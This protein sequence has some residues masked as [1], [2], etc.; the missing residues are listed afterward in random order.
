MLDEKGF[1]KLIS[2]SKL[3]SGD[4]DA[5]L[6]K[7][8]SKLR[9]LKDEDLALFR[10]LLEQYFDYLYRWD[11][12]AAA[13]YDNDGC[14]DDAFMDWR[15]GL[16][17]AGKVVYDAVS[18]DPDALAEFEVGRVEGLLDLAAEIW[19]ERHPAEEMASPTIVNREPLGEAFPEDDEAWFKSR[20]PRLTARKILQSRETIVPAMSCGPFTL[21]IGGDYQ[22]A[23]QLYRNF[24]DLFGSCFLDPDPDAD[25]VIVKGHAV[26]EDH[27]LSRLNEARA[28]VPRHKG[29]IRL[30]FGP[31]ARN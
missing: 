4:L 17:L 8:K 3:A 6:A 5:R 22:S 28:K 1:W 25:E 31:L 23:M 7:L 19:Q 9:K 11:L 20:F 27:V 16:I 12:W 24:R 26:D 15:A 10:G 21:I 2:Q 13:Y 29:E 30:N 18:Q 14:S